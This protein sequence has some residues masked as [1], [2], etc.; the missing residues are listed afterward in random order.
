M[1]EA[2]QEGSTAGRLVG[3]AGGG[4]QLASQPEAVPIR[5]LGGRDTLLRLTSLRQRGGGN[6]LLGEVPLEFD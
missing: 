3:P 5:K 6:R 4:C 2:F 1:V